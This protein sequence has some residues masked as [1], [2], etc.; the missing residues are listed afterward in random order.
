M[1]I[2]LTGASSGIGYYTALEF[3]KSKD[4]LVFVISRNK[5][6]LSGLKTVFEKSKGGGKLVI[7]TGDLKDKKDRNTFKTLIGDRISSLDILIN[8]AG[9]LVN[10]PFEKLS[11]DDWEDIYVTNVF[12]AAALIQDM[13]PLLSFAEIKQSGYRS[14]ILNIG[15]MGGLNGTSKFAGLSAYSSSKAALAVMT[16]CL[17]EEF[18]ERKIAVNGLALGSVNTEMFSS[19]FP[20]MQASCTAESMAGYI[21][22]F[23]LKGSNYYNGKNLPVS[24]GTP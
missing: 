5:E 19:A 17:A 7:L 9:L 10:K 4:N 22:E 1:N 18:K 6:K 21:A 11:M 20:G 15:S 23:A 12:A 8:N 2:L 13:L 24:H 16:E 3:L 14:H